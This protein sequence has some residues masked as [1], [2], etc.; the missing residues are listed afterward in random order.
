MGPQV[1]QGREK[2]REDTLREVG[3]PGVASTAPVAMQCRLASPP[4][5]CS[6]GRP[7]GSAARCS[8]SPAAP[9]AAAVRLGGRRARVAAFGQGVCRRCNGPSIVHGHPGSTS[10]QPEVVCRPQLMAAGPHVAL[11]VADVAHGAELGLREQLGLEP[12]GQAGAV[13]REGGGVRGQ[14]LHGSGGLRGPRH[15][16]RSSSPADRGPEIAPRW[17]ALKGWLHPLLHSV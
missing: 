7:G 13:Q 8:A 12:G 14:R 15:G 17:A 5:V 9:A 10:R 4:P 1:R 6:S 11:Q 2:R 16:P 3:S